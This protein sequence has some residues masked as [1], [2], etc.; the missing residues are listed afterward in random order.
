MQIF[1]RIAICSRLN[2]S[3]VVRIVPALP[4]GNQDHFGA[5]GKSTDVENMRQSVHFKKAAPSRV[6]TRRRALTEQQAKLRHLVLG[7]IA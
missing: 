6:G 3:S 5:T 2:G 1:R 7:V 4:N